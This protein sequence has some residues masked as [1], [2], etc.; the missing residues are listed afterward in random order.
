MGAGWPPKPRWALCV[1]LPC[2][3]GVLQKLLTR[4]DSIKF[5]NLVEMPRILRSR[6]ARFWIASLARVSQL[7]YR[8]FLVAKCS[9]SIATIDS[10]FKR[11]HHPWRDCCV[12]RIS[13]STPLSSS[14]SSSQR[15]GSLSMNA[16]YMTYNHR[17]RLSSSH[18]SR[19]MIRLHKNTMKKRWKWRLPA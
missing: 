18:S 10:S 13:W 17:K 12:G 14:I 9:C 4:K 5:M 7:H 11:N 16:S 3:N 15:R 6:P 19:I 2:V 8:R 1:A